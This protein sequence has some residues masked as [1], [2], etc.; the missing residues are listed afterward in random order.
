MNP[1]PPHPILYEINAWVWLRELARKHRRP[2][3]LATVPG[4]EWDAVSSL[5]FDAVWL[6]GVWERSPRGLAVARGNPGLAADFQRAL[7]DLRPEDVVGSPYCVRRYE[8]DPG[9][10]GPEALASARAELAARGLRL[11]LD[12][13]P[14]HVAPDHPW[15]ETHPEHFVRGSPEDLARE[16]GAFLK[17]G[18]RVYACGRD[19]FFPPWPDVLQLDAFAPGLRAA[20]AQTVRSI[21]AQCDGVR[22]D[23]AM[24]LLNDVFARTWGERVGARPPEEFWTALIPAVRNDHP[25]FLFL[26]E[27]YWDLEWE[28]QQQGFDYCY[29]KRLYDRLER[30]DAEGVR[31]HLVAD[32]ALPAQARPLRREP[33]RAARRGPFPPGKDRAAAVAALAVPGAK[34]LHEGQLQGRKVRLPVFLNRRPEEPADRD[35]EGFYRRLL[36]EIAGEPFRTGRWAP[37]GATGWPDNSTHRNLVAWGWEKGTARRLVAV[38]LSGAPAQALLR[39]PWDDLR[40]TTWRLEDPLSGREFRTARGRDGGSQPLRLAGRLGQPFLAADR[41]PLSRGATPRDGESR[42]ARSPRPPPR[43]G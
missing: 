34:L 2:V 28:L 8:V 32:P 21:A 9:L 3:S 16:P 10:G 31:L 36:A 15:A 19:P 41:P 42:P 26:A 27:A 18:G 38:N 22:C 35:L 43:T 20:A 23:M 12:F 30:G 7:P 33:R 1:W 6:M 24:L 17:V 5:G 14:N 25:G 11:L 13:V 37:C 29:D 4:E 40:G 39:P